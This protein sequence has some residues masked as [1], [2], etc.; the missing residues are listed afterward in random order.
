[1]VV[2]MGGLVAVMFAR[3]PKAGESDHLYGILLTFCASW[4]WAL[5]TV[6]CR[7]L[8]NKKYPP[9]VIVGWAIILG[10]IPLPFTV[11]ANVFGKI[12]GAP[13]EFWAAV[14][15]LSVVCTFTAYLIWNYALTKLPASKVTESVYFIPPA[16]MFFG[17]LILK[18]QVGWLLF[19]GATLIIAG[20]YLANWQKKSSTN[21][22]KNS[23]ILAK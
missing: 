8:I 23:K 21:P 17:W 5:Y 12:F 1:M 13:W 19:L 20:V 18:E 2:S 14:G 11:T 9:L 15:F 6:M 10:L 22:Q 16:A 7:R 4:A 3:P